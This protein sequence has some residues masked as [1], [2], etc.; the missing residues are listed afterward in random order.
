MEVLKL[1]YCPCV[2]GRP[3]FYLHVS[4]KIALILASFGVIDPGRI[5]YF[6]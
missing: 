2:L 4:E 1:T 5:Q 3:T 6:Y